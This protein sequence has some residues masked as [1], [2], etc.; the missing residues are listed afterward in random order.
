MKSTKG[1]T[2][3]DSIYLTL[4]SV[5]L[6]L[7]QCLSTIPYWS[8]TRHAV[9]ASFSIYYFVVSTS[10]FLVLS[11]GLEP[12]MTGFLRPLAVPIRISHESILFGAPEE[13]RTPKIYVLS[14]TRIPI[15]SPGHYLATHKGIEP[16]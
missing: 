7:Y 3:I 1:L 16:S 4:P 13:T 2:C 8:I 12:T 10:Y 11:V 15:P 14:V 6:C 9:R 5:S